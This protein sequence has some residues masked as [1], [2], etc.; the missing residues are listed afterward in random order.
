M[1]G[2]AALIAI[3]KSQWR[4]LRGLF[5]LA[6]RVTVERLKGSRVHGQIVGEIFSQPR[7]LLVHICVPLTRNRRLV[8]TFR[9]T[10]VK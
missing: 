3:A 4:A 9:T 8:V 7:A 2:R 6:L 5:V 10:R 1:R